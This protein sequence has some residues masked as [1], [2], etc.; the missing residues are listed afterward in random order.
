MA[1]GTK[2]LEVV[3]KCLQQGA[4]DFLLKPVTISA[5]STIWRNVYFKNSER[6]LLKNVHDEQA[7]LHKEIATLES[8]LADAVITPIKV[9]KFEGE[10][11]SV[12]RHLFIFSRP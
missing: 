6:T 9:K 10:Q 4:V 7:T 11:R 8:H 1:S 5:L 2:E 12:F 3:Y